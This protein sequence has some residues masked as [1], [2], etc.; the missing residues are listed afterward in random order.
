MTKGEPLGG[1]CVVG[2]VLDTYP[3]LLHSFVEFGFRP[4]ANEFM[5]RQLASRITIEVACRILGVDLNSFLEVLNS[6][7][8]LPRASLAVVDT[9]LPAPTSSA[10]TCSCCQEHGATV[11]HGQMTGQ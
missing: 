11:L 1:Q 6:R 10:P 4:L 3:E 9:K 7:I 5:R 2:E 8:R